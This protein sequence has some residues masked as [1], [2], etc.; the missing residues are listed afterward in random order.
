MTLK[1][2]FYFLSP[3]EVV[4]VTP[5]NLEEVAEWC[6]GKISETESRRVEGRMD[7]Y[8]WVP[9]PKGTA[10]SWAFPGMFITKRVVVTEKNELK[11]TYSVF[12]KDYFNKNY[13]ISP[14]EAVE[15]TWERQA[16]EAGKTAHPSNTPRETTHGL[17]KPELATG[18]LNEV[19]LTISNTGARVDVEKTQAALYAAGSNMVLQREILSE[20]AVDTTPLVG[21][22]YRDE[23]KARAQEHEAVVR[24]AAQDPHRA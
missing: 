21:V 9:T 2:D 11:V 15:G 1:T 10:I 18:P 12:R 14:N 7:K 20:A 5:K 24:R 16:R 17:V 6:G 3:V 8:V 13:F 19:D 23:A 22:N 4:R